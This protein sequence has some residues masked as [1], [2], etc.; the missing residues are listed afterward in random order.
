M[1]LAGWSGTGGSPVL[2]VRGGIV[3]RREVFGRLGRAARV[4]EVPAAAGTGKT[5]LPRS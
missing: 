1:D 3:S 5:L 4:T 2:A